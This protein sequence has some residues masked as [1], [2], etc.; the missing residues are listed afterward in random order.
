M[1]KKDERTRYEKPELK[2]LFESE[3]AIGACS[4][5]AI[6]A[7]CGGGS[8]ASQICGGGGALVSGS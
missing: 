6:D 2:T 1:T 3:Y 4:G 5:G 7:D 8:T